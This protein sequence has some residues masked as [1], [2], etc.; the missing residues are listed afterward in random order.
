MKKI[1][2]VL[3]SLFLCLALTG[4]KSSDYKK[5]EELFIMV[6]ILQQQKYMLR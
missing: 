6:I 3:L 2:L 1:I 5:A 4:C